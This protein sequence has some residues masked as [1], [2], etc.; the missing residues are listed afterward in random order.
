MN[1]D[2]LIK[3]NYAFVAFLIL[4]S[5]LMVTYYENPERLI[6]GEW[7]ETAWHIERDNASDTISM[8]SPIY[9][10]LK[11][12]ILKNVQ[13]LQLGVWKFNSDGTLRSQDLAQKGDLEWF[14]KGRGHILELRKDGKSMESFQIQTIN[15][16]KLVL[17][18]NFDLQVKGII[19]IVLERKDNINQYAKKI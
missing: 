5:V 3:I 6:R 19:E 11:N 17:H 13:A 7:E 1:R 9:Q 10:G 16:D 4:I 14:I 15:K 12:E 8:D 18:L 2:V